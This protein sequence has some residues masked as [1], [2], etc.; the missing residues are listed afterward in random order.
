M[1]S[2]HLSTERRNELL[3]EI[4]RV[5]GHVNDGVEPSRLFEPMLDVLVE[6]SESEFGF[7]GEVFH[8]DNGNPWLQTH[9]I[10][11]IAWDE[12][13]QRI[14]EENART[15]FEFRNLESLFGRVLQSDESL[16]SNSP[17]TDKRAGGTPDGHPP[18]HSFMGLPFYRGDRMVGMVGV[19]NRKGGYDSTIQEALV[20]VLSGCSFIIETFRLA[21]ERQLFAAQLKDSEALHRGI[22][23]AAVDSIITVDD[24]GMIVS[25]NRAVIRM[26][27][28]E[29]AELVGQSMSMLM[30]DR[31]VANHHR[32]IEKYLETRQTGIVGVGREIVGRHKCG[33]EI[34]LELAVSEV[35]QGDRILFTGILRDITDRKRAEKER[36]DAYAQLVAVLDSCS[37]VSVVA[38]DTQGMIT[39]FNRGAENMLGYKAEEMVGKQTPAILHEPAEIEAYGKVLTK[40]YGTEVSGFRVFVEPA[41][42]N[43]FDRREWTYIHADGHRIRADLTITA[44]RDE[45]EQI[46][47]YL[48][49]A[50]DVTVRHQAELQL[51]EAKE[52][53]ESASKAKSDFLANTSHEIRTPINGIIGMQELLRQTQLT[54]EQSQYIDA[55]GNCA[56]VLLNVINE[57]LDYS[58]IEAGHL[59]IEH[60]PVELR[61]QIRDSLEPLQIRARQKGLRFTIEV[62]PDVPSHVLTDPIRL[63]QI[64][65]NLVGN[66]VKFTSSGSIGVSVGVESEESGLAVLQVAV[67][68][69]GPGIEKTVQEAIFNPFTQ[70]DS[71]TTRRFGGTGLGLS[72]ASRL[73]ELLGGDIQLESEPGSGTTFRFSVRAQITDAAPPESNSTDQDEETRPDAADHDTPGLKVLLAEDHPVNQ[74]FASRILQ[75]HHHNVV[76]ATNGQEAVDHVD[77]QDFDVVLMDVQMPIMDGLEAIARIRQ[78]EKGTG[79]RLPII[80]LTAHAMNGYDQKCYAAGADAYI[81][82]PLRP[83]DLFDTID[84]LVQQ[85]ANAVTAAESPEKEPVMTN[86][87][88]R[89]SASISRETILDNTGDDIELAEELIEIFQDDLPQTLQQLVDAIGEED[90]D[91]VAR[92]AHSLKSPLTMFG[93]ETG[94]EQSHRLE[95]AARDG[96]SESMQ[97]EFQN[98][99]TTLTMVS[100]ELSGLKL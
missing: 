36:S 11:N 59:K 80:A 72:I 17:A 1:T 81:S 21:R 37:Q 87:Q 90:L 4:I 31:F 41:E 58:K 92:L 98:L 39:V 12:A 19:A 46:T 67:R 63:T 32:Y 69:T 85:R 53:A 91:T 97:T 14:Y 15:G 42:R 25:V 9:A 60:V 34:P 26:F 30:P 83:Q 94:K 75:R 18:L 23:E 24:G 10:T 3:S 71:S 70:S 28:Y 65:M 52:T 88:R 56:R 78:K 27:G 55:L 49:V 93:A 33:T 16:I 86:N 13:T 57:V 68:D 100:D 89:P 66:A 74:L 5:Q 45:Q 20:P 44:V 2:T 51:I 22:L 76:V 95:L 7:I 6:Y 38:T 35:R 77:Q 43:E 48:G 99:R 82:K 96:Q 50:V 54:D 47:G 40:R 84:K 73:V 8:D 29:P 61:G 79:R 64:L 62:D